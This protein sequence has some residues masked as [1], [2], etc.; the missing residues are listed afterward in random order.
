[1]SASSPPRGAMLTARPTATS[2]TGGPARAREA[3]LLVFAL[4]I[5]LLAGVLLLGAQPVSTWPVALAP[6]FALSA[7]AAGVHGALRLLA[8]GADPLLMPLAFLLNGLG[9]VLIRRVDIAQGTSWA[10]TQLG[11]TVLGWTVFVLVLAIVREHTALTRLSYTFGLLTIVLL[12][13]P[14]LPVIG[15]EVNGARLWV[16][17]GP[18]RL[19]PGELAKLTL[20]VF[21][22]GYLD[23]T[24]AL[25]SIA[26]QRIGPLHL[27]APRHLAP[28]LTAVGLSL[29]VLVFQ[30]DLGSS[31]LLFGTVVV[32]LH[33]ATGR[34]AYALVGL[35]SFALGA[36]VAFRLFGH[37]RDRVAIWLDPFADPLGDGYQLAQVLFAFANG[38]VTGTGL[39][40]GQPA[41]IPFAHTDAIFAVAGEELGV[42]GASAIIVAFLLLV[43]RGMRVAVQ[44]RDD[45][46]TLLAVGLTA[47]LALEVFVIIGGLTRVIPLTG[48]ALPL[49][50]YGGSALLSNLVLLALLV[51]LSDDAT[52][53][54]ALSRS[55]AT[56]GG[57]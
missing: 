55:P 48:I 53:V 7:V 23:R 24:R 29:L 37:L 16:D 3:S 1:V 51:R 12:A 6:V 38:G 20:V 25:L 26:Q 17:I 57:S 18:L 52:R 5:V 28:L 47:I 19:Q 2:P 10:T 11:W 46:G 8:P 40:M 13:L 31:L 14:L 32:M 15:R 35:A 21:L 4:A 9:L 39:G 42:L 44:A 30:R 49:V 43:A 27:P 50:S 54:P 33:V 56:G 36:V 34:L 45:V 22:A 41:K